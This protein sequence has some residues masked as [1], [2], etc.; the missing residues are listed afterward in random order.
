MT[1]PT[2]TRTPVNA[3]T[4]QALHS[5]SFDAMFDAGMVEWHDDMLVAVY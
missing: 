5:L 3:T 2:V 1:T 4:A